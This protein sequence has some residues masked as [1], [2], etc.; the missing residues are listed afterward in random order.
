MSQLIDLED[1]ASLEQ[2]GNALLKIPSFVVSMTKKIMEIPESR[3]IVLNQ[4][5]EELNTHFDA[6]LA[7]S[8]LRPVQRLAEIETVLGIDDFSY[9][10]EDHE[11]TI[12]EKIQSIE[13]QLVNFEYRPTISLVETKTPKTK[14]ELRASLLVNALT[15]SGKN[16]LSTPEIMTFLKCKLPENCKIDEGVQNLRK[17]KQDVVKKAEK[18]FSHITTD[19]KKTGHKD[20]R[21]I[22]V[23]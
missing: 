10:D 7:T 22:L 18:M 12:P 2:L 20:V 23:S 6:K 3:E 17:V 11:P 9:D 1:T 15:E 16:Y 21:L 19:K 4:V 8:E 13:E 14:T 5:K